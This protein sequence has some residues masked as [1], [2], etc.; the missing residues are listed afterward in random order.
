MACWRW[1]VSKPFSIFASHSSRLQPSQRRSSAV[2]ERPCLCRWLETGYAGG[3]L[4]PT[5]ETAG[6]LAL[7]RQ[8]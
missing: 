6:K 3:L 4:I 2:L 1:S 5:L 8:R 7:T